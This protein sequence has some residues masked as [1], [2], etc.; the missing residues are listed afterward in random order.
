MYA[1]ET[2]TCPRNHSDTRIDLRYLWENYDHLTMADSPVRWGILTRF[3]TRADIFPPNPELE[4]QQ[5]LAEQPALPNPP[6]CSGQIRQPVILPDNVYGNHAPTDIL[7]NDSDDVF[8][9]PSRRPRPGPSMAQK[10]ELGTFSD[11]AQKSDITAKMVQEGGAKLFHLLLKKA[12]VPVRSPSSKPSREVPDVCNVREWHYRDLMHLPKDAQEKWKTTCLEE[13]ESLRKQEVFKLTN[14][15]AGCKTV[16]SRW[17]FDVK[18]DSRY[19]ARLVAQG[20][21][22]VEGIDFN[23]LFSPVVHFESMRLVFALAALKGWYMMGVDVCMAYLYGKLDEEIYMHQPEGFIARGQESKVIKLQRALY[24]LKQ[25]GLAWWKEL[26]QSMKTLGF[27]HV[28]SDA[29]IYVC[30]EGTEIILVVVYVDDAM[31]CQGTLRKH[32][33]T[34]THSIS[35]PH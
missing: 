34:P 6:R 12:A 14:L 8:S 11:L 2:P 13:L 24:S 25:A 15:P 31:F 4:R 16:G 32:Y 19:K 21:S 10:T 28:N 26:T 27:S 29:G 7:S 9:E 18:I 30:R 3:P 17:V 23:E 1:P 33:Y 22:Q 20:F 5:M 35:T